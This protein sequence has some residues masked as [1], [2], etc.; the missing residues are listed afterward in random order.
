MDEAERRRC[1]TLT[2]TQ[3]ADLSGARSIHLLYFAKFSFPQSEGT[4]MERSQHKLGI[5]RG[6]MYLGISCAFFLAGCNSKPPASSPAADQAA[7]R[8]ADENWA[9]AA[10]SKKVDDWVAFY[11]KD[12]VILPPNDKKVDNPEGIRKYIGEL[13]G[14]PGL[15]INQGSY[16]LTVDVHGKPLTD[17]GKTLEIWKQQ[18][19]GSWKC[20]MDMWSSDSPPTA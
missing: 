4:I 18:G 11:S 6:T 7:V 17:H 20:I 15:S 9:K 12:A 16:T 5:I 14:A 2:T 19:D 10:Q 13:L 1:G 8:Q 3:L